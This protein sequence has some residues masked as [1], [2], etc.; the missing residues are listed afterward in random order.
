MAVAAKNLKVGNGGD[1]GVIIGPLQNKMQYEKVK[2]LYA[3]AE[4]NKFRV[5]D[6]DDI[7]SRSSKGFFLQPKIIDNPPDDSLIMTEEQMVLTTHTIPFYAHANN[8]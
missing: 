8:G 6:G 4:K 1:K 7:T 5:H 2:N 3:E